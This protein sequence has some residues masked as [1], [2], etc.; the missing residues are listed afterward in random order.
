MSCGYPGRGTRQAARERWPPY[1]NSHQLFS[2]ASS[3]MGLEEEES[4]V[5]VAEHAP[6]FVFGLWE[7]EDAV[8]P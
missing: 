1:L 3:G 7:V 6:F 8:A 4:D 5:R 2:Q